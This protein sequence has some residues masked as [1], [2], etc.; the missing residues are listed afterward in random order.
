ME[1]W[2]QMGAQFGSQLKGKL[3][4]EVGIRW[5]NLL[6]L[7]G[8]LWQS[9]T[10]GAKLIEY[11]LLEQTSSATMRLG[12]RRPAPATTKH[13]EQYAGILR[14]NLFQ[15]EVGSFANAAPSK[16]TQSSVGL[17]QMVSTLE[18]R[19]FFLGF[20]IIYD[21]KTKQESPYGTGDALGSAFLGRVVAAE[22]YV[23]IRQGE[24]TLRLNLVDRSGAKAPAQSATAQGSAPPSTAQKGDMKVR[25]QGNEFFLR[26]E[27]LDAELNNF[28]KLL[29]QARVVPFEKDGGFEGYQIKAID[30]GSLYD[31]LGLK[32]ED[33][34]LEVNGN[35]IDSPEKAMELFKVL[36]SEKNFSLKLQRGG[37]PVNLTYHVQ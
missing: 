18:L 12:N 14:A 2:A 30:P 35:Q 29:N 22:N 34:I 8:V 5:I 37:D 6:F 3:T 16:P 31:K 32:N 20:A 7:L 28:T 9:A 27:E 26:S 21:K 23:E 13:L 19:G 25:Q 10:W 33:V 36:R 11:E 15:V 17:N 1:Q 4:L 24:E